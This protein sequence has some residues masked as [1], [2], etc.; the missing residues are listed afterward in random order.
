MLEHRYNQQALGEIYQSS[1]WAHLA[2][3]I[4]LIVHIVMWALLCEFNIT[5]DTQAWR[6]F[7]RKFC[8]KTKT[9]AEE[10]QK[11]ASSSDAA[12]IT[13]SLP[14]YRS[15]VLPPY[16]NNVI[17]MNLPPLYE[18]EDSDDDSQNWRNLTYPT[19]AYFGQHRVVWN[20]FITISTEDK[21]LTEDVVGSVVFDTSNE[22]SRSRN[23]KSRCIIQ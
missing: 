15:E 6:R 3:N 9:N 18:E 20:T 10:Q 12:S 14:S 1:M 17:R 2:E 11:E 13:S 21:D 7:R 19:P 23:S 4:V 8:S 5:I 16:T 22:T